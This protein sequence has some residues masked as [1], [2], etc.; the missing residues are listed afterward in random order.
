M[1]E[2]LKKL[3]ETGIKVL[4]LVEK[5]VDKLPD[6]LGAAWDALVTR[7]QI[8]GIVA[9]IA[10]S[11]GTV[12]CLWIIYTYVKALKK[13]GNTVNTDPFHLIAAMCAAGGAC[14]LSAGILFQP[15]FWFMAVAPEQYILSEMILH[16]MK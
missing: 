2:F 6:G 8:T 5:G 1:E 7:A 15:K 3:S 12:V 16:I 13:A 14:G 11:V 4:D 10:A 9:L